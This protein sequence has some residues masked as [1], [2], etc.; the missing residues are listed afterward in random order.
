MV[1]IP[2]FSFC[3][4]ENTNWET[5]AFII[6][7]IKIRNALLELNKSYIDQLNQLFRQE[8][9]LSILIMNMCY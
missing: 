3:T 9:R 7:I 8:N 5:F 2:T 1:R 4:N 6:V